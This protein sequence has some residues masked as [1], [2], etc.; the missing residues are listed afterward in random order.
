[1]NGGLP[2]F[3]YLNSDEFRYAFHVYDKVGKYFRLSENVGLNFKSQ[4]EGSI[5]IYDIFAKYGYRMMH[6]MS[7]TDGILS[8]A[9]AWKWTRERKF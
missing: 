8:L 2:L 7:D 1:M 5:W 4:F 6:I 3:D 9:G